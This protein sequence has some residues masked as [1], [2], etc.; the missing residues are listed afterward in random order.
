MNL[1]IFVEIFNIMS[2]KTTKKLFLLDGMA[3]IFRAHYAFIKN[4]RISSKG[5]NTS[6]LYGYTNTVLEIIQKEIP[7]HLG[8]SFDTKAPT[9]R[10]EMFEAYKAGRQETPEDIIISIPL[11]KQLT[12]AFNIP[13]LV[14]DGF[15][16]DDIIG[17]LAK[18]AEL[19]GFDEIFMMTPDK[20][21]CQLVSEKI[22]VYKPA[23]NSSI[24]IIHFDVST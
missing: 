6:A 9:F 18:K 5:L 8:V 15:E 20:D 2:E 12:E 7:T 16:A 21:Y 24:D 11:I 10:H 17:T 3:L 13:V 19:A 23:F 1:S 4:P 14:L 22:K